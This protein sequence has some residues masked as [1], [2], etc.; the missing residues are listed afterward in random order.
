MRLSVLTG[1]PK[2]RAPRAKK[3]PP[4]AAAAEAGASGSSGGGAAQAPKPGVT[5]AGKKGP[6]GGGG[7]SS[8]SHFRGVTQH[9]YTLRWEAHL[10][11]PDAVR[12]KTAGS[13]RTKGRQVGLE[14]GSLRQHVMTSLL[15]DRHV[16]PTSLQAPPRLCNHSPP[17][18]LHMC[19]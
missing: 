1:A 6:R 19:V 9:R 4:D 5:A 3:D 14:H 17:K 11:D 8:T 2:P 13:S 10:W 15:I 12:C 7:K 16:S 18:M